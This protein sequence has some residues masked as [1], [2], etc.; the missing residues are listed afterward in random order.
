MSDER[1]GRARNVMLLGVVVFLVSAMLALLPALIGA[2]LGR[3]VAAGAAVG[4]IVA[5][6]L[7]LHGAIDWWRR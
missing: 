6:S 5:M 1:R 2:K 3:Y 4:L 7:M